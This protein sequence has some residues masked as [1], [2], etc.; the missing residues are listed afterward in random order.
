MG[1]SKPD[2]LILDLNMP[3]MDGFRMLQTVRGTAE[4]AG[5]SI[6]VVS[7]IDAAEIQSRGGV[8]AGVRVLP[9]PIPFHE[10]Q[11]MAEQIA[12]QQPAGAQTT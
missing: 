11:T 7:G 4:L 3:G 5:M 6:V 12:R 2:L 10:L 8:P 9:K 1:Q